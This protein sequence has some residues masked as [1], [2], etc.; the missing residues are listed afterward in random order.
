MSELI[1]QYREAW[2]AAGRVGNGRVMLAFS[3]CCMPTTEEAVA[4]YRSRIDSYMAALAAAASGWTSGTA[5]KDYAGYDKMVAAIKAETFDSQ[6][7]KG[8]CWAGNPAELRAMIADYERAVPFEVASLQ[9]NQHGMPLEQAKR[10]L[11]LFAAEVMPHF[12]EAHQPAL[13]GHE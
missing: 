1:G 11:S 7:A 8:T 5:S 12:A 4:A 13:A 2:R 6:R 3:M 9:V 10:S